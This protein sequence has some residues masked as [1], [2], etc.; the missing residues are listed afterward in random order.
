MPGLYIVFTSFYFLFVDVCLIQSGVFASLPIIPRFSVFC[1]LLPRPVKTPEKVNTGTDA[2]TPAHTE[3]D[4]P[5]EHIDIISD[6]P[7]EEP[8]QDAQDHH[9]LTPDENPFAFACGSS[10]PW[11]D[12]SWTTEN[13]LDVL[14]ALAMDTTDIMGDEPAEVSGEV[15]PEPV[16]VSQEPAEV[17]GEVEPAGVSGEVEPAE[18]SGEVEPAQFSGK[19]EPAEVS[20]PAEN[21]PGTEPEVQPKK[22]RRVDESKL[23]PARLA[24]LE[25]KRANSRQWHPKFESKGVLKKPKSE[26]AVAASSKEPAPLPENPP[27]LASQFGSL[28][29]ARNFFVKDWISK[30]GL[31]PSKERRAAALKAWM[32]S[33]LRADIRATRS[34]TKH[35]LEWNLT[36]G[37]SW[38][39]K[40]CIFRKKSVDE[41]S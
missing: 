30:C 18:V 32:E 24:Q 9:G 23:T 34:G 11:L 21:H 14:A 2:V 33:S 29:E 13:S 7:E 37:T 12:P 10:E 3:L 16:E 26:A 8:W 27:M 5:S 40:T 20:G 25:K 17:S 6:G 36:L 35:R 15:R 1:V 41:T 4:A 38:N 31:P 22:S 39:Q 19:V 28:D